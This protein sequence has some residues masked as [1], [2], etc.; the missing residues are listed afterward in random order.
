MT[1]SIQILASLLCGGRMGK[2]ES[3]E[4]LFIGVSCRDSMRESFYFQVDK[5][6]KYHMKNSRKTF[7]LPKLSVYKL[8]IETN[9]NKD[10]YD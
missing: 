6:P 7:M 2:S 4:I 10:G 8:G 5:S 3:R 1:G 9:P